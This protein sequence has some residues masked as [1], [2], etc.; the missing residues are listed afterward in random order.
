MY[1][2][3][4][5]GALAVA[6]SLSSPAMAVEPGSWHCEK[7]PV[8]HPDVQAGIA[9]I[10]SQPSLRFIILEYI[11][12]YDAKEIMAACRAF[13][14]GQPSEISCLNGRRDWNEIRQA[15]PDDLIGLPPMRH[16]EHMQTL[17]TA[18]NPVWAA[19]AF[20]E[21]VGA[22]RDDGFSLEVGDG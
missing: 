7:P 5:F 19:H 22:L 14:D 18:E 9:S 10:S 11:K 15:F 4:S 1:T 6:L 3:I 21:S 13:A 16:A 12:Q 20:C 8:L 17:Q 2:K